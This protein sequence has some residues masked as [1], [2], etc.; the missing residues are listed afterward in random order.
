MGTSLANGGAQV[1]T[2]EHVMAALAAARVDNVIIDLDG[3][4][5]PIRDGSF[6]DYVHALRDV[7]LTSQGVKPRIVR[8]KNRVTTTGGNGQSYS[9][10]MNTGLTVVAS[11]DFDHSAIG[12]QSGDSVSTLRVLRLN[13][14][15]RVHLVSRRTKKSCTIEGWHWEL[16]STTL[17]F[18]PRM[19]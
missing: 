11:I 19:V 10:T 13:L 2:V 1:S 17:W 7:G 15:Q 3:Q 5:V 4:E 18:W 6:Q 16:H 9:A 12:R 14:L 8:V